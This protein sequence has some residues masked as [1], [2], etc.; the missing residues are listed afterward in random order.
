MTKIKTREPIPDQEPY[1]KFLNAR[2]AGLLEQL[3][4]TVKGRDEAHSKWVRTFILLKGGTLRDWA[5]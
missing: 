2:V 4:N 1:G 5:T 3:Q